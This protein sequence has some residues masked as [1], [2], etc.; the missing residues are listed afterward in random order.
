VVVV[1][2]L[3]V[4]VVTPGKVV[5]PPGVV[6]PPSLSLDAVHAERAI[7]AASSIVAMVRRFV[8]VF[9]SSP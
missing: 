4:V 3:M 6:V 8:A 1:N 5:S 7:T 2:R 9:M